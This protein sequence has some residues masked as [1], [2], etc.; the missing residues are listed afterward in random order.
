MYGL[1]QDD[2][3]EAVCVVQMLIG[4]FS[5]EEFLKRDEALKKYVKAVY[6]SAET[7]ERVAF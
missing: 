7:G 3:A 5:G 1:N 2:T 4:A 6:L